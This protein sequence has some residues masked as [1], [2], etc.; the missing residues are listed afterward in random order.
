MKL[1]Y[2]VYGHTGEYDTYQEWN[3]CAFQTE[4][5][6]E[7]RVKELM[8]LMEE[9]KPEYGNQ[10]SIEKMRSHENGDISFT[11]YPGGTGY[12]CYALEFL[13]K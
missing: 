11:T 10:K 6:A 9:I 12:S 8:K 1:I 5:A 7:N 2:I 3:V 13:E 4:E